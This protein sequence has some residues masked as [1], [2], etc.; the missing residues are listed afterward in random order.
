MKR[1]AVLFLIGLM[2]VQTAVRADMIETKKEG[3]LNGRILSKDDKQVRFRDAKGKEHQYAKA[4]VL[5]MDVD[6]GSA[7]VADKP[8]TEQMKIKAAKLLEAAKKAPAAI[9][10]G[11]DDLTEKFIGQ[12]GQPLDRSAA[13]AKSEAL[14][15]AMDQAGQSS[16]A[17]TGKVNVANKEFYRQQNEAR[18][19]AASSSGGK[20]GRFSSL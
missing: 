15:K 1:S 10:K 18:D 9:K 16:A 11:T 3:I 2:G 4:D 12:V 19:A 8:L 17:M 5:Y 13:N 7:A 14:A 6:A 20:K